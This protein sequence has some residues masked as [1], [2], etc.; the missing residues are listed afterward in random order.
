MRR[1]VVKFKII[2]P[3]VVSR[4]G[5]VIAL[6][7]FV[8]LQLVKINLRKNSPSMQLVLINVKEKV[9]SI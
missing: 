2:N 5:H 4:T 9:P 8:C 1:E 3:Y 7:Q 6:F